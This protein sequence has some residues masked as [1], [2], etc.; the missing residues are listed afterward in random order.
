MP[1]ISI[2]FN[3]P[4]HLQVMEAASVLGMSLSRYVVTTVLA[5]SERVLREATSRDARPAR[6]QSEHVKKLKRQMDAQ[7]KAAMEKRDAG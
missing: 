2:K 3:G 1:Q 5:D 4:Q 6:S 7:A